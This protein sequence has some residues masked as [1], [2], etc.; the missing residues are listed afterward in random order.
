LLV[1]D[2]GVHGAVIKIGNGLDSFQQKGER[3]TVGAGYSTVRLA[4][5]TAKKGLSGLEFA[6]GIPGNIG[7]AV[8]MNA[9]AHGSEISK[10]LESAK[11]LLETGEYIELTNE[12]LNFRY[13]TT[14]LQETIRGIVL[15][16]TFR[17]QKGDH[18]E[19]TA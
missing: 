3:I 11:V 9:G 1:D 8:Y 4:M 2:A 10:V 12:E 5:L 17:L 6:G 7:G 13:R 19:I 18:H 16:A 14:I 15:E